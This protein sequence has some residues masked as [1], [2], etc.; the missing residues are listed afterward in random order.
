[1]TYTYDEILERTIYTVVEEGTDVAA[2][3]ELARRFKSMNR[4]T[5]EYVLC[6]LEMLMNEAVDE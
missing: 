3:V 2:A 4:T 6:R 1:M 5:Q